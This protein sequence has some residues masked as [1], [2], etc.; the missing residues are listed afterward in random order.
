MIQQS[1]NSGT[2]K[3]GMEDEGIGGIVGYVSENT[4]V[5]HNLNMVPF[6]NQMVETQSELRK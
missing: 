3:T 2:I 5:H 1:F 4:V 6:D